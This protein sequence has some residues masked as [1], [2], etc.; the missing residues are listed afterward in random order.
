MK[1]L[2]FSKRSARQAAEARPRAA[3]AVRAP[4]TASPLRPERRRPVV[5]RRVEPGEQD[6]RDRMLQHG[7]SAGFTEFVARRVRESGARGTH[8]IDL[9]ARVIGSAFRVQPSPK[10]RGTPHLFA[11]AGPSGAGKTTVLAKLARR[12][13]GANR[14]VVCASLDPVGLGA[15]ERIGGREADV[16]RAEIPLVA[17]RGAADVKAVVRRHRDADAILLDTP[18]FS[19]RGGDGLAAFAREFGRLHRIE[20]LDVYLVLPAS[21]GRSSLELCTQAFA[22]LGSSA[23]VVTKLDE[24]D[25]PASVL[26]CVLAAELP[27]ALLC[28]GQDLRAHLWRPKPD[29]FADLFLRGRI[30]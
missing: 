4:Q 8:A 14:R 20:P 24:T 13:A 15:L 19:P 28:D 22:P 23:A 29:H 17:V 2:P 1:F 10:R 26:E 18:G 12:L 25:E 7:A 16:D 11:F 30:A 3:A 21:L 9:A 6:V 5:V 27:L